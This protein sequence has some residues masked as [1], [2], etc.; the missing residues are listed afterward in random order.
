M[1]SKSIT[2]CRRFVS[3]FLEKKNDFK[4]GLHKHKMRS[5]EDDPC[6]VQQPPGRNG[7]R[8]VMVFIRHVDDAANARL[9][10]N[11]SAFVAGKESD[12]NR[13]VLHIGGILV[14]NSV[15]FSMAD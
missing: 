1:A 9:N 7:L 4:V 3:N 6:H 8:T 10:Y 5:L 15:Q 13:A 14:Q 2:I 12:V 11:L